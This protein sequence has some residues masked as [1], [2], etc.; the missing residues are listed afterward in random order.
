MKKIWSNEEI[1]QYR[2]EH[3]QYIFYYNK[4]DDKIIVPKLYGLGLTINFAHIGSLLFLF[5]PIF[6]L[7][8]LSLINK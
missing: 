5:V 3:K 4:E 8:I 6:L 7:G 2:M 1:A